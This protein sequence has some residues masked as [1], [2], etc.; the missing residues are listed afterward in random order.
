MTGKDFFLWGGG[1]HCSIVALAQ[2]QYRTSLA[3]ISVF[4]KIRIA[5]ASYAEHYVWLYVRLYVCM[6]VCMYVCRYVCV[7]AILTHAH[8]HMY[9]YIY[10]YTHIHVYIHTHARTHTCIC[11]CV[12]ACKDGVE[13]PGSLLFSGRKVFLETFHYKRLTWV[14]GRQ[15]CHNATDIIHIYKYIHTYTYCQSLGAS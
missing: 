13:T 11:V 1:G 2:T 10:I 4:C 12:C 6:Y 8:I 7:H 5:M 3:W 9:I 14:L 15:G